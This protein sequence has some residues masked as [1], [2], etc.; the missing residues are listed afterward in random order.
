MRPLIHLLTYLGYQFL[1]NCFLSHI[2]I[3]MRY[4]KIVIM[5]S[6]IWE[7]ILSSICTKAVVLQ[8]TSGKFD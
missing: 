2:L 4:I 6:V 5:V 3:Q 1:R 8:D 7:N